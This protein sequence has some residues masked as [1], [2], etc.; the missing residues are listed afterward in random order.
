MLAVVDRGSG[1]L[2]GSLIAMWPG[3]VICVFKL[4]RK[5]EC[6]RYRTFGITR[7]FIGEVDSFL[8]RELRQ[9]I[10]DDR[11]VQ[12]CNG[13]VALSVMAMGGCILLLAGE[14]PSR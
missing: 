12:G 10:Y 7:S 4:L 9:I 8:G 6:V 14:R 5:P 1:L 11:N 3:I 13:K 2:L